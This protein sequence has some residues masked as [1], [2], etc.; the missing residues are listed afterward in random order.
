MFVLYWALITNNVLFLILVNGTSVI[1]ETLD[2]RLKCYNCTW[3]NSGVIKGQRGRGLTRDVQVENPS[4]TNT[5]VVDINNGV[6]VKELIKEAGKLLQGLFLS[7]LL[8]KTLESKIIK[9][10]L[11][12]N[13]N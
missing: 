13:F 12:K 11:F 10:L 3:I 9:R 4:C 7:H 8:V 2:S 5:C 6:C 1:N